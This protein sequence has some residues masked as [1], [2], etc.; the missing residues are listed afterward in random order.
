MNLKNKE[1]RR[2]RGVMENKKKE[3]DYNNV[4]LE[5]NNQLN[6]NNGIGNGKPPSINKKEKMYKTE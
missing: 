2:T 4:I 3:R 5:D 1:N 6:K